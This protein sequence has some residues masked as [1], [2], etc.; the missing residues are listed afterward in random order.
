MAIIEIIT[1][2]KCKDCKFLHRHPIHRKDG[3]LSKR[4]RIV[5][6]KGHFLHKGERTIACSEFNP[7]WNEK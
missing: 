6:E 5:C 4:S 7:F 2:A 1:T 3:Y